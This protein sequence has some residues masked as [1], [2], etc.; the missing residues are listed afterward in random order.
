M[1]YLLLLALLGV[2]AFCSAQNNENSELKKLMEKYQK[3]NVVTT[4]GIQRPHTL[5]SEKTYVFTLPNGNKVHRLPQ[6]NMPCVAS[7]VSQFNMP[8]AGSPGMI[9]RGKNAIPDPSRPAAV[10]V[11]NKNK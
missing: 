10:L 6:D 8:N 7:D 5:L 4:P 3:K 9:Q 1:K 11:V 2:S